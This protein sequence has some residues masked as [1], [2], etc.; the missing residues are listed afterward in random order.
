MQ[1]VALQSRVNQETASLERSTCMLLVSR[2]SISTVVQGN[3][4]RATAVH[5]LMPHL[6]KKQPTPRIRRCTLH[7]NFRIKFRS[8]SRSSCTMTDSQAS[9][10]TMSPNSFAMEGPMVALLMPFKPNNLEIDDASFIKYLKYLWSGGI[11][12]V[13]VNGSTG[14]FP[15]MT[16]AERK[17]AAEL[18]R[19]HWLGTVVVGISSTAV[20]DCLELLEHASTQVTTATNGQRTVADAVLLLPP[21]YF[22]SVPDQGIEN[23]ILAVLQKTQ[24]PSYLYNY[25]VHTG[26]LVSTQS[27]KNVAEQLPLLRGIKCTVTAMTDAT[28]YKETMPHL[29]AYLGGIEAQALEGLQ[30]GLDGVIAGGMSA[31]LPQLV[32]KVDASFRKGEVKEAQAAQVTLNKWVSTRDDLKLM[33]VGAGKAAMSKVVPGFP[34]AVRPPLVEVNTELQKKLV[35]QYPASSQLQSAD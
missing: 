20:A 2:N 14:E 7:P 26:N 21:Y 33:D 11:K 34:S 35:S 3:N 19:S 13:V 27:Y 10:K 31:V 9:N 28:S 15:S 25:S 8:V 17:H 30:K 5:Q 12:N 24:L 4:V 16:L 6:V 1:Q 32:T 18:C 22:A 29:Q 23:F